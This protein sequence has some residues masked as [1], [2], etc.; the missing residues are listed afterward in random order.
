M[1]ASQP[2]YDVVIVGAGP[3]GL[4]L[5]L[6]LARRGH[7]VAVV[8]RRA[9][10]Y[11]L[12][13]AVHYDFEIARAFAAV[14]LADDLAKITQPASTYDWQNAEG[15]TLLHFDW[16][17]V[18]PTGW[19]MATMFSQ[20]DLEAVLLSHAVAAGVTVLRGSAVDGLS[21]DEET[22]RLALQDG[23]ELDARYVVGCDGARS[24]VREH[25]ALPAH[26]LGFA[27]DWLVVDLKPRD[28]FTWTY[29]LNLQ[30]CDPAR[31]TTAVAGGPGRRRFEFMRLPDESV[32]DLER[33]DR[34]WE[35]VQPWGLN[36]TNAELER[37]VV[38]R[39]EACWAE[40]WREG[41]VFIAGDAAHRMP[42]F[43]GQGMC[44]G[45][46]D[47]S[48]LGWKLDLVLRGVAGDD[49]LDTYDT[50]RIAHLQSAIEQSVALGGVICVTDPEAVEARDTAMLAGGG[51]PAVVLP[52]VAPPTLGPGLTHRTTGSP[53]PS[54]GTLAFQPTVQTPEGRVG[55][56]DDVLGSCFDLIG[57]IN[58]HELLGEDRV[59]DLDRLG[60]RL[61]TVVPAGA[62]VPEGAVGDIDDVLLP[63][64]REMAHDV[65]AVRPD[66]Y[67]YGAVAAS[68]AV[69]LVDGLRAG[70]RAGLRG[71]EA[72]LGASLEVDL[73]ARLGAAGAP[74]G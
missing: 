28:D 8:E 25:L 21:Q 69:D 74:V 30:I 14:G 51:D 58:L 15:K 39:F 18:G 36:P 13:R 46:R 63:H 31:P 50:E 56:W 12:P 44:S 11:P 2:S 40:R 20:P 29:P 38:Y 33:A 27:F 57:T 24:F 9:T 72:G 6:D 53:A 45:I 22:V 48:N 55:L 7:D 65:V 16:S 61:T 1:T 52:P 47:A 19:P 17:G 35:L 3:V 23:A 10:P 32:A 54:A 64:L 49:L 59:T 71:L 68:E 26:E 41:R 70:L 67:L 60:V 5:S 66:G 37:A 42:P 62:P 4:F 34:V 43:A 73:K